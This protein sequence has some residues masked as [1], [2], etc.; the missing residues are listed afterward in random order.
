MIGLD[1]TALIDL[2]KG[3]EELYKLLREID[4]EI[5]FNDLSYLELMAGSDPKKHQNEEKFYDK[6]YQSARSLNLSRN[7]SKKA[8]DIIWNLRKK[9]ITIHVIDAT[10]A[11]I[12][13]E[14]NVKVLITK[15]INNI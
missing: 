13:L 6:L 11:A 12:Y 4:E 1:T 15:N 5:V 10:I 9:G 8:R 3:D 14:N 7:S 2:Y